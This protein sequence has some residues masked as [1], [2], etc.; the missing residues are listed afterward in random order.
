MTIRNPVEWS[1][2]Q[3]VNTARALSSVGHSLHH[4][5]DTIHSPA[6]AVRRIRARDIADVLKRG[7]EDF[8]VYRD[9]VVMLCVVYAVIGLVLMRLTFGADLLPLLFPMASG[10][11]I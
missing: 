11:A 10:F 9:D 3:L 5:Q 2:A 4:V 8:Q 6:P 7:F 1:G